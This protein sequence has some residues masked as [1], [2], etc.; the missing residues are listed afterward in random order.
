MVDVGLKMGLSQS[1]QDFARQIRS[2]T[3][4][5]QILPFA[6]GYAL[7]ERD[8]KDELDERKIEERVT[9]LISAVAAFAFE[10]FQHPYHRRVREVLV[11]NLLS[12]RAK[13]LRRCRFDFSASEKIFHE[14][15]FGPIRRLP[16]LC[17][18]RSVDLLYG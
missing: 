6:S 2:E 8:R 10:R 16:L 9:N 7:L 1:I 3:G 13:A 11:D 14:A 18:T 15:R 12:Q 17:E 4:L 5:Q